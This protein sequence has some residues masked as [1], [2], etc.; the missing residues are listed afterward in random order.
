VGGAV[1][2]RITRLIPDKAQTAI[3]QC[4]ALSPNLDSGNAIIDAARTNPQVREILSH[5]L[6]PRHPSQLYEALLEG[7][8]LFVCLITIRL[9][10]VNRMD[11]RPVAFS[12][13]IR[14]CGSLEKT[15]RVPDAR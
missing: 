11:S 7:V 8:I 13:S 10:S 4:S 9:D 1:P 3:D 15:F 5:I 6:N 2:Q 14:S 12:F